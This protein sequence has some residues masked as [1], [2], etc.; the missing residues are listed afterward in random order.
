MGNTTDTGDVNNTDDED[1]TRASDNSMGGNTDMDKG[2]SGNGNT[3][4]VRGSSATV[5]K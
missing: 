4:S 2:T 1:A 5:A 3:E